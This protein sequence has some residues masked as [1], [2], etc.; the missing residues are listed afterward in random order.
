M[1]SA[2]STWRGERGD[3]SEGHVGVLCHLHI[4]SREGERGRE[5]RGGGEGRRCGE[6]HYIIISLLSITPSDYST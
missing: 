3:S 4:L 2:Y 5:V 6:S 1:P